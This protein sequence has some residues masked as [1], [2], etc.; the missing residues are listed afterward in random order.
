VI[1]ASG[2]EVSML[3][4]SKLR[5]LQMGGLG[6]GFKRQA[7]ARARRRYRNIADYEE[8]TGAAAIS[9]S[10]RRNPCYG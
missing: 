2:M 10:K 3:R 4:C 5:I 1:G 6:A 9:R 8:Q 7:C